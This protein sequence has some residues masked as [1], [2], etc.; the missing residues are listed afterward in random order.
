MWLYEQSEAR[1]HDD[2]WDALRK[3]DEKG[4]EDKGRQSGGVGCFLPR[5]AFKLVCL[6]FCR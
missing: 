4:R 5:P 2:K 1:K 3:R 6:D